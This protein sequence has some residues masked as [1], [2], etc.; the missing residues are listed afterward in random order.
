LIPGFIHPSIFQQHLKS[1][2]GTHQGS[3]EK[4]ILITNNFFL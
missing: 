1:L 3:L 4:I 2:P